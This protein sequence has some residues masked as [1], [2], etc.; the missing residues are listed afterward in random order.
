MSMKF[1]SILSSLRRLIR[2]S[3]GW[4]RMQK[5]GSPCLYVTRSSS[6][7]VLTALATFLALDR[8]SRDSCYSEIQSKEANPTSRRGLKA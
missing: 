3:D 7:T 1:P 4:A 2:L 6:S 8:Y 5:L